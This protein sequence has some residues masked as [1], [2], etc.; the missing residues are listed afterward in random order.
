MYVAPA[1]MS[2]TDV[3]NKYIARQLNYDP[4][5]D[6]ATF[7]LPFNLV[8]AE[9]AFWFYIKRDNSSHIDCYARDL[10]L[11]GHRWVG[12]EWEAFANPVSAYVGG[13]DARTW[14]AQDDL[15]LGL[16]ASFDQSHQDGTVVAISNNSE[17]KVRVSFTSARKLQA[18]VKNSNGDVKTLNMTLEPHPGFNFIVVAYDRGSSVKLYVNGVVVAQDTPTNFGL[19]GETMN[20]ALGAT[21]DAGGS[22]SNQ[23][24][25]VVVDD[26]FVAKSVLTDAKIRE[27]YE[28]YIIAA[29]LM[30][31]EDVTPA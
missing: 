10:G 23:L 2:T 1:E 24:P 7:T 3:Q 25:R 11:P 9:G 5:G 26:V 12:T 27:I 8:A 30:Q 31:V 15:T 22:S 17:A 28:S 14:A 20:L 29:P 16:W 19:F 21:V 6:M 13:V 4:P 18:M